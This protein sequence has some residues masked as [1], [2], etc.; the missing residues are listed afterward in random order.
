MVRLELHRNGTVPHL[1]GVAVALD[2]TVMASVATVVAVVAM[3]S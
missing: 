3:V 2:V 1:E